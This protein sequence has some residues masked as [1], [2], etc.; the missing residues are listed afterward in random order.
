M[1]LNCGKKEFFL[2]IAYCRVNVID[3]YKY[4]RILI[5]F[6]LISLKNILENIYWVRVAIQEKKMAIRV[7]QLWLYL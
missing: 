1:L 6:V 4:K 7:K 3:I 2:L 5:Y